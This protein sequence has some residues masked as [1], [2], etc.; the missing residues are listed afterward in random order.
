MT[1][2]QVILQSIQSIFIGETFSPQ[3]LLF[4]NILSYWWVVAPFILWSI[5]NSVFVLYMRTSW[6]VATKRVVLEVKIP[7]S[8]TKPLKAMENFFNAFWASYDPP[9]D[10]RTTFFEGKIITAT[11][12]EIVS[13]EGVPHFYIRVPAMF[14]K[15]LE[16]TLYAQYPEIEL[17]EAPDYVATVPQDIPNQDWDMWGCDFMTLKPDVYPLRTYADFFEENGEVRDEKNKVDPMA[18]LLELF[19]HIGKGEYIWFQVNAKPISV[20]ENDFV[21]RG[22]KEVDKIMQRAKAQPAKQSGLVDFLN[23]TVDYFVEVVL[24]IIGIFVPVG[25]PEEKASTQKQ[26]LFPPAMLIS[27]GERETITAIERKISKTCYECNIRFI[28]LARRENFNSGIKSFGPGFTAQFGTQ[29]TN[30]V[31][32]WKPTL[33]KIQSPD[34]FAKARLFVKKRNMFAKYRDR[35]PYPGSTFVLSTEELATIYHFPGFEVAPVAA[36]QR[37]E[38]KKA[39]PPSTLPIEE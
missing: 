23:N 35:E 14:R 2:D 34:I 33:T 32:P 31:K 22:K 12:F 19:T 25:T 6:G 4:R 24:K 30:G 13:L 20:K 15:L 21:K 1:P 7:Q 9:T 3:I 8:V 18:S 39:P 11:S 26:E 36:L 5:L 29:N 17:V 38:I 37:I 10:W 27:P 28:Y 16:S